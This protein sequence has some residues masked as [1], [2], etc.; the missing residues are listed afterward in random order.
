MGILRTDPRLTPLMETL[1]M[2]K[3]KTFGAIY[4]IDN[5]KLD[6]NQFQKYESIP[7]LTWTNF[8]FACRV[9]KPSIVI[10][11]KA[12]KGQ[13]V[14]PEFD[15]F[16]KDITE[17]YERYGPMDTDPRHSLWCRLSHTPCSITL[18][19][20]PNLIS[21]WHW[22]IEP[23][24]FFIR[25]CEAFL[26]ASV[27]I[28]RQQS[29]QNTLCRCRSHRKGAPADY[30][31][32]LARGDP[33]KWG[34]SLCTTDGQRWGVD[35]GSEGGLNHFLGTSSGTLYKFFPGTPSETTRTTSPS[36]RPAN[37]SPMPWRST[38]WEQR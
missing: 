18:D 20:I 38:T 4:G 9:I 26:C 35:G 23:V 32:Q 36:S 21:D 37:L 10:I 12:F 17:V 11:V 29:K 28:R 27:Q 8:S 6:F 16:T 34:V 19:C 30:I 1:R 31:P 25:L 15:A 2:I 5:I 33:N 7:Y 13:L 22:K 3:R 24:Q 14:I